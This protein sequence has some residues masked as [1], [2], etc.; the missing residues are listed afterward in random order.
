MDATASGSIQLRLGTETPDCI[1]V[2]STDVPTS[3]LGV[4]GV[5]AATSL[6]LG[7]LILGICVG[8]APPPAAPVSP[9]RRAEGGRA[10]ATAIFVLF[11]RR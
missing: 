5:R 7:V 6:D 2:R 1:G 8:G 4:G 10:Y 3:A 9:A 11:A